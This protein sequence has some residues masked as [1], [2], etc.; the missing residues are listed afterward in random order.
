MINPSGYPA[1][2]TE[3][4]YSASIRSKLSDF[5]LPPLPTPSLSPQVNWV[6][7]LVDTM[8]SLFVVNSID[9]LYKVTTMKPDVQVDTVAGLVPV[10][11]VGVAIVWVDVYDIDTSS[12]K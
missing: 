8:A 4:A 2:V 3:A 10:S 9:L 11:A 6:S 7:C 12:H 1:T 5:S